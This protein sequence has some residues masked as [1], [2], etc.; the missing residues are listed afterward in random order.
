MQTREN[1][2]IHVP[3]VVARHV[4][5]E[6]R[7]LDARPALA[8]KMLAMRAIRHPTPRPNPHPLQATQNVVGQKRRKLPGLVGHDRLYDSLLGLF[9]RQSPETT[10]DDLGKNHVLGL[11]G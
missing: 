5:A 7:E 8:G 1:V 2:P 10:A 4:I 11:S 3:K 9:F 6:A